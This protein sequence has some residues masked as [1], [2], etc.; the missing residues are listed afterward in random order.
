MGIFKE[1]KDG[2]GDLAEL[3]VQTFTGSV[4]T[5]IHGGAGS[6]LDWTKLIAESKKS[7]GAVS[8]AAST[9]VKIDGDTRLFF[10][11]DLTADLLKAHR[12]AVD[13][14]VQYRAGLLEMLK[15]ALDFV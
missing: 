12:D 15:D 10:G 14:A 6:A 9:T 4:T 13:A 3:E 8:L 1:I 7:T 5:A 11:D 2:I